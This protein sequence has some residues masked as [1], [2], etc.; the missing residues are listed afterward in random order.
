MK[1]LL[2]L[3]SWLVLSL[4]IAF[5]QDSATELYQAAKSHA[6]AGELEAAL[7]AL[8]QAAAS[9]FRGL[10]RLR[11]D[12]EFDALREN[13]RFARVLLSVRRNVFP[14]EEGAHYGDFDFWVGN[15][16]VFSSD[17]NKAGTN[18]ITTVENGCVLQELWTGASGITGRSLNFYDPN[19][20]K[21]RQHWVSP[22][23]TLIDI[24]GGL[25]DGSMVLAGSIFYTGTGQEANFRGTWTLLDDGRVR[26]FFEQHDA[27]GDAWNPWF[28]GFYVRAED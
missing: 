12:S 15:W 17:G 2:F 9:G 5:A 4:N 3:A 10:P 19:K 13:D 26:Q 8:E 27:D 28:E 6:A 25:V 7:D 18:R 14:C 22:T 16:D 23:G 24:E 21:W 11:A 20:D 1:S